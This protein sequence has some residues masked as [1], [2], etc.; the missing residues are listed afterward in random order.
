MT[1]TNLLC[2]VKFRGRSNVSVL[3]Y[4]F[5]NKINT[6]KTRLLQRR[7]VGKVF[8]PTLRLALTFQTVRRLLDYKDRPASCSLNM[9]PQTKHFSSV[10]APSRVE[11]RQCAWN[12]PRG[13]RSPNKSLSCRGPQPAPAESKDF[14]QAVLCLRS[15]RPWRND[16]LFT[17]CISLDHSC[18]P[19][20]V[21]E[22][23]RREWG[24]R[25]REG[26]RE[27]GR[28]AGKEK[29]LSEESSWAPSTDVWEHGR[30]K[31]TRNM[32]SERSK[33]EK[34]PQKMSSRDEEDAPQ[35]SLRWTAANS[36]VRSLLT[37]Q[38]SLPLQKESSGREQRLS[39]CLSTRFLHSVCAVSRW[40]LFTH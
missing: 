28:E 1:I 39:T 18:L 2:K 36:V 9:K 19:R 16:S 33:D 8:L 5:V 24:R 38:N 34:D 30:K 12:E 26:R 23:E 27:G 3:P 7:S 4:V 20:E 17:F 37:E 21:Y 25:G 22:A 10:L 14:T 35:W 15:V 32:Q 31:R 6:R 11:C 40:L 29:T 13:L